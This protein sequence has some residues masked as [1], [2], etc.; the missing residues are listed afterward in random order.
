[1]LKFKEY[2]RNQTGQITR[3]NIFESQIKIDKQAQLKLQN[4]K[5]KPKLQKFIG[6]VESQQFEED[7]QLHKL[8]I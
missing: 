1:M 6:D 7:R 3:R 5:Q 8:Q 4:E 2:F